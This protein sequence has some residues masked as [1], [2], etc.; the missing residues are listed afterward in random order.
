MA[1]IELTIVHIPPEVLQEL[2]DIRAT[3]ARIEGK[4]TELSDIT[5]TEDADTKTLIVKTD[6]L[7]A[8]LANLGSGNNVTLQA[9]LDAAKLDA[10]TQTAILTASDAAI[11]L[12]IARVNDTLAA[13]PP[14]VAPTGSAA[15]LILQSA[16]LPD[17]V[18]GQPYS[19]S[20]VITGGSVPPLTV[21]ATPATENGLTINADGTVSGTPEAD[22][23]ASFDLALTDAATPPNTGGGTVTIT[24]ATPA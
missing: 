11:N 15:P 2:S 12:E 23:T 14:V 5:A 7:I 17:A 21:T 13:L 10:K 9:A 18:T 1:L 3:L 19:G 4:M 20:L 22:G 16:T 8:A 6:A 24:S